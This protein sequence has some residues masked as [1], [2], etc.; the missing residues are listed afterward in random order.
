MANE[1]DLMKGRLSSKRRRL[2]IKPRKR[3]S[4]RRRRTVGEHGERWRNVELKKDS[5]LSK[6]H[7]P[8]EHFIAPC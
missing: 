1:L 3:D 8:V 6:F 2:S 4:G 5:D 7:T